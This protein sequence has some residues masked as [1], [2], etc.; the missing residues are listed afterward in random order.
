VEA[1][2]STLFG[3]K[4]K[5]TGE[6]LE[7]LFT[8]DGQ[9]QAGFDGKGIIDSKSPEMTGVSRNFIIIEKK[10]N[11]EILVPGLCAVG[12]GDGTWTSK[13]PI[14]GKPWV[15][16]GLRVPNLI[17]LQSKMLV[18]V[19]WEKNSGYE[20]GFFNS[21]SYVSGGSP[22]ASQPSAL[23]E[24]KS[25]ASQWFPRKDKKASL[26]VGF[27][28]ADSRCVVR[29]GSTEVASLKKAFDKG[30]KVGF[31]FSK[32]VFTLDNL[33]ITGKL[34]RKW[35]ETRIEEL[36]KAGKLKLQ[37]EPQGSFPAPP[38]PGG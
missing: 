22:K 26:K 36:R 9:M 23:K 15:E 25:H 21:V 27:G 38:A 17:G 3:G 7:V 24:Y 4:A 16:F 35:A 11:V 29:I 2:S 28:L 30:G 34:D 6:D 5:V 31:Q 19:N 8:G 10:D 37:Y 33:K 12:L 13:F 32:L 20:T 1:N 18:R 14:A